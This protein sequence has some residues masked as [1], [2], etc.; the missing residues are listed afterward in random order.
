MAAIQLLL[1][2]DWICGSF[3]FIT[4]I[5]SETVEVKQIIV[6]AVILA[7]SDSR[8]NIMAG[9]VPEEEFFPSESIA[10]RILEDSVEAD[11]LEFASEL[12]PTQYE[13]LRTRIDSYLDHG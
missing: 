6:V 5:L 7:L 3:I 8:I 4:Q 9:F 11:I 13:I 12:L 2:V 1:E 10:G